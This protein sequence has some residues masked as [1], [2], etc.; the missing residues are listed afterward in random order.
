M[1]VKNKNVY[2]NNYIL[3][4]NTINILDYNSEGLML[5]NWEG[6]GRRRPWP[7]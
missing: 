6:C 2:L 3:F 5:M 7:I 4:K 1:E